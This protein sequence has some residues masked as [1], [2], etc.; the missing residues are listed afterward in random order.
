[1]F[2]TN[3]KNKLTAL[4]SKFRFSFPENL[5]GRLILSGFGFVIILVVLI[6]FY[7]SGEPAPFSVVQTTNERLAKTGQEYVV[8]SAT[9][10]ALITAA[11]TLL[12]KPGGYL[13]NDKMPPGIYLDNIPNWE[14]GVLVQ[15]R[16][17][18][19]SMRESF[20]RSQSQSVEDPDLIIS[21]PRF[22]FDNNS[23]IF[24][25]SESEYR[26][27]I[28][29]LNSYFQRISDQFMDLGPLGGIRGPQ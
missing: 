1:M 13:S 23:W 8:G 15:V 16:D 21:E 6:G 20:S 11:E 27:A 25:P 10:A 4:P 2:W 22:H 3:F 7:W 29:Y 28:G 9:T 18:S 19:R 17:L 26:E 14:F 5:R 12:D 24:P